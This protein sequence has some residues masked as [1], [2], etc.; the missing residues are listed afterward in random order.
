MK[1]KNKQT[2]ISVSDAADK[3]GVSPRSV[4]NYIKGKEISAVKVGKSWYINMAS[5][6]AF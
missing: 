5:L 3:L 1:I 6:D 4:L 2:D